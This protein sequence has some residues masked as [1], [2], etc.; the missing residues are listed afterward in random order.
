[1]NSPLEQIETIDDFFGRV[2]RAETEFEIV[3]GKTEVFVFR[4]ATDTSELYAQ[5]VKAQEFAD[6]VLKGQVSEA[7]K[8]YVVRDLRT[9]YYCAMLA[10]MHTARCT[11]KPDL[12][13]KGQEQTFVRVEVPKFT[14]AD[15]LRLASHNANWFDAIRTEVDQRLGVETTSQ[16]LAAVLAAKKD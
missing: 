11:I 5:R 16:M 14:Q 7:M 15:F 9:L 12:E 10:A 1:M 2:E 8:P 6:T 3:I 4:G 13:P